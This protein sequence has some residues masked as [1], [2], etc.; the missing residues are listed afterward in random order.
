M[1]T[2]LLKEHKSLE[3]LQDNNNHCHFYIVSGWYKHRLRRTT[4]TE[5]HAF[6]VKHSQCVL[7]SHKKKEISVT[8]TPKIN[9]TLLYCRVVFK[10]N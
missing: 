10:E 3:K 7:K 2:K 6:N 5:K 9:D 8:V 4:S 1:Q